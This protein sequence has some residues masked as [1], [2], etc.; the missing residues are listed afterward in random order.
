MY[1]LWRL[2]F[3]CKKRLL[4]ALGIRSLLAGNCNPLWQ[5]ASLFAVLGL[6]ISTPKILSERVLFH[7]GIPC[8][9][10]S[11]AAFQ[12]VFLAFCEG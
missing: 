5:A 10:I 1:E 12:G 8:V 2:V 3:H 11:F 6:V 7:K 4:T 9:D